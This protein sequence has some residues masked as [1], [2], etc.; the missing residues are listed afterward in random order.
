MGNRSLSDGRSYGLLGE[1]ALIPLV[2]LEY[3]AVWDNNWSGIDG[4]P[5]NAAAYRVRSYLKVITNYNAGP[6]DWNCFC[7]LTRSAKQYWWHEAAETIMEIRLKRIGSIGYWP[8]W[9]SFE[10]PALWQFEIPAVESNQIGRYCRQAPTM[11]A[12]RVRSKALKGNTNYTAGSSDLDV[13]CDWQDRC[14]N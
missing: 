8:C 14:N 11:P 2:T 13:L 6:L 7:D 5:Q 10:G 1:T 9:N 4:A 12:Y 3:P